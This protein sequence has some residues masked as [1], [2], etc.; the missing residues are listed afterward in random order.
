MDANKLNTLLLEN[1]WIECSSDTINILNEETAAENKKTVR[2]EMAKFR[3][4]QVITLLLNVNVVRS[5]NISPV[6]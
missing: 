2:Y 6:K 3:L 1:V 4:K 5:I